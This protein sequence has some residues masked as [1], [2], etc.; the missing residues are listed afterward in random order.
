MV[1]FDAE[2]GDEG[3]VYFGAFPVDRLV[4]PQ[5]VGKTRIDNDHQ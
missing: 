1:A 2:D 4:N 5:K 3:W